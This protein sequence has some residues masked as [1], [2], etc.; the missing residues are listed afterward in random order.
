MVSVNTR[1][2][3]DMST[4]LEEVIKTWPPAELDRQ[5]EA[6]HLSPLSLEYVCHLPSLFPE[7]PPGIQSWYRNMVLILIGLGTWLNTDKAF[8][9]CDWTQ[10][11]LLYKLLRLWWA[12]AEIYS[13]SSHPRQ[14]SYASSFAYWT[15]HYQSGVD[16][17]F[18]WS[19]PNLC[20]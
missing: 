18:L 20:T 13:C 14:V 5:S 6:L 1:K 17:L 3:C 2:V 9:A 12:G 11:R 8:Y 15:C 16:C 7:A 4:L 10:V 19:L